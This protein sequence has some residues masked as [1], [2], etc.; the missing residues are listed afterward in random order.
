MYDLI[1]DVYSFLLS[2]I[3]PCPGGPGY[4]YIGATTLTC[5]ATGAWSSNPGKCVVKDCGAQNVAIPGNG[6]R[7]G[8]AFTFGASVQFKCNTGFVPAPAVSDD[9]KAYTRTCGANGKWTGEDFRCPPKE[10]K[11]PG[12]VPFAARQVIHDP[13]KMT[14]VTNRRLRSIVLD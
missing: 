12:A 8:V 2:L 6:K 14:Y 11:D 5:L 4:D 10:C 7:T 13:K 1:N 3:P 9:T